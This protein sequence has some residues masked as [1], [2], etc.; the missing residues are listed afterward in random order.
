[1]RGS[2]GF[3]GGTEQNY[4]AGERISFS[5][6]MRLLLLPCFVTR[7][8]CAVSVPMVLHFSLAMWKP[9]EWY[10]LQGLCYLP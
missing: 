8:A 3:S 9:W 10:L 4:G 6:A 2:E 5:L 1:M 7:V